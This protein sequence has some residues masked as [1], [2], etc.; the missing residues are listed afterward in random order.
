[1]ASIYE[2]DQAILDCIDEE[3]GEILDSE[4]LD[5]L[6]LERSKKVESVACWVKDISY[7]TAAL[8]AEKQTIDH[9]IKVNENKIK[10]LKGWLSYALD[11]SKFSTSKVKVTWRKSEQVKIT[12]P[13]HIDPEYLVQQAPKPDKKLIKQRLK[14][15]WTVNGAELVENNNIQIK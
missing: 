4:K 13:A 1:M 9:R 5:A 3:T 11:G 8:K 6:E 14:S 7:E 2:I 10:S 15:G 12:D